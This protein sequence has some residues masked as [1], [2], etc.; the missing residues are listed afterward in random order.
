MIPS[1]IAGVTTVNGKRN[2][3]RLLNA[4]VNRKTDVKRSSG[5]FVRKPYITM[6]PDAIPT[7]LINT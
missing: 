7:R 2:P 4:V 5:W 3:V 1:L 6:I